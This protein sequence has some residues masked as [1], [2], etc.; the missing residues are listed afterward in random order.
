MRIREASLEDLEEIREINLEA[1]RRIPSVG[2]DGMR[3]KRDLKHF[4]KHEDFRVYVAEEDKI[5]GFAIMRVKNINRRFRFDRLERPPIE[6]RESYA[7]IMYIA[8]KPDYQGRGIGK[9]L[10]KK[11][12][13]E[14]KLLGKRGIFGEFTEASPAAIKIAESFGGQRLSADIWYKFDF[15][16]FKK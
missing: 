4:I 15:R 7:Y 9:L 3:D 2:F 5:I 11:L 13:E 14:A 1:F 10:M 16:V 6:D 8:V 12:I